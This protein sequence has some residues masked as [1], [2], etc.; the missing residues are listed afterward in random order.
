VETQRRLDEMAEARRNESWAKAAWENVRGCRPGGAPSA[1]YEA[2]FKAGFVDY[3]TA[4]GSGEAPPVPPRR[5][6]T[7]AYQ[8]PGGRGAVEAWFAGFQHGAAAAKNGGY[9]R[10]VVLRS[11]AVHQQ[12]APPPSLP[13]PGFDPG[14]LPPLPPPNGMPEQ[15][16]TPRPAGAAELE[17]PPGQGTGQARPKPVTEASAA[18]ADSEEPPHQAADRE[19][20]DAPSPPRFQLGLE[21]LST[22]GPPFP[23]KD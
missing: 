3:L 13:A 15:L 21:P 22:P 10:W 6:W 8:T 7:T 11:P 5:Y 17:Q 20:D 23:G 16:P 14:S 12:P 19:A 1:D 18:L 4:G 9:R 2:G